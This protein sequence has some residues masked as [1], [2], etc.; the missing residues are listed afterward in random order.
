MK[1]EDLV[2]DIL[3]EGRNEAIAKWGNTKEVNQALD[4][5]F[6]KK[7]GVRFKVMN[8]LNDIDHWHSKKTF[9]EFKE[10]VDSFRSNSQNKENKKYNLTITDDGKGRLLEQFNGYEIWSVNSYYSAKQLGRFYK[11]QSTKWCISTEGGEYYWNGQHKNDTFYFLIRKQKQNNQ[12]DKIAFEF[13]ANGNIK[14]WD[15]ENRQNTFKDQIIINH[16]KQNYKWIDKIT[17]SQRYFKTP[18]L[19]IENIKDNIVN[20]YG[21]IYL[22]D[23]N[24][25]ELPWKRQYIVQYL[26][27]SL[28]LSN[29]NLK[30][31][32]NF[33]KYIEGNLELANNPIESFNNFPLEI[34]EDLYIT[35]QLPQELKERVKGNILII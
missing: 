3:L 18:G 23:Q 32:E 8:P 27:G 11:G 2:R 22:D 29:N 25:T 10:F 14:I 24:L 1:F 9:K 15:K 35:F 20:V 16:M 13:K 19:K 7:N 4:K 28:Y 33:P 26:Y 21:D 12:F 30:D 31:F 5:F 34:R 17:N 6:D